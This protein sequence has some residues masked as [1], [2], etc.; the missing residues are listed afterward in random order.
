MKQDKEKN[1]VSAVA[2]LGSDPALVRPFL[3][4]INAELSAHFEKYEIICVNDACRAAADEVR[5]YSAGDN[6]VPVTLVNM[7][8]RQ[9]VE[10]C[11]NAGID[12]S[13]GDYVFEFDSLLIPYDPS[14]IFECYQ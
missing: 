11:M 12:I 9:G 5:N 14:L 8:V 7:S 13:I 10:L 2:Y 1:F 6:N 4:M 3:D